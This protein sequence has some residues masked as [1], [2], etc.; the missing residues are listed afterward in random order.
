M[1]HTHTHT[2]THIYIYTHTHT[3]IYTHTYIKDVLY[4]TTHSTNFLAYSDPYFSFQDLKV[5]FAGLVA[6]WFGKGQN[7]ASYTYFM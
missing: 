4:S 2:H 6:V 3:Y 5:L 1:L 7:T